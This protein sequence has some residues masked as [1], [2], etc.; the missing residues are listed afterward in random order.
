[1]NFLE[2]LIVKKVSGITE[3]ISKIDETKIRELVSEVKNKKLQ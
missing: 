2:K 1:M 3:T